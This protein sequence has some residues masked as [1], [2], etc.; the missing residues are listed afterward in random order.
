MKKWWIVSALIFLTACGDN[1]SGGGSSS[2]TVHSG[3][4]IQAAVA[5]APAHSTVFVEPGVYHESPA[6]ANAITLSKDGVEI[7][8]RSTPGHPVVLENVPWLGVEPA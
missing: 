3:E 7:V 1:D 2:I 6:A 5:A 8:G 4:S